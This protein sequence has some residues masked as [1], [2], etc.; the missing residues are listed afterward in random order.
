MEPES[1]QQLAI[2]PPSAEDIT[3]PRKT[4]PSPPSDMRLVDLDND[5][6]VMSSPTLLEPSSAARVV[7]GVKPLS[8]SQSNDRPHSKSD[9]SP[10]ILPHAS[11]STP[12]VAALLDAS[13]AVTHAVQNLTLFSLF[14]IDIES[15]VRSQRMLFG[16]AIARMWQSQWFVA[17]FT[18]IFIAVLVLFFLQEPKSSMTMV[19]IVWA[20]VCFFYLQ[21]LTLVDVRIMGEMVGAFEFWFLQVINLIAF[22]ATCFS[23]LEEADGVAI[24]TGRDHTVQLWSDICWNFVGFAGCAVVGVADALMIR[25]QLKIALILFWSLNLFRCLWWWIWVTFQRPY[26]LPL[27]ICIWTEC[28]STQIIRLQTTMTFAVFSAK[29][30]FSLLRY[31]HAL[32]ILKTAVVMGIDS[33]QAVDADSGCPGYVRSSAS[34]A[35]GASS[36]MGVFPKMISP[37]AS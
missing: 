24:F 34:A 3:F 5:E 15:R 25:R 21:I 23:L 37:E 14:G 33:T 17:Q 10:I 12:P 26:T 4:T 36:S 35:S 27:D 9:S 11:K 20:V 7:I 29:Y 8:E 18:G 28:F 22:V 2:V 30:A 6:S 16:T 32:V 13:D 1:P 19:Y 31:P